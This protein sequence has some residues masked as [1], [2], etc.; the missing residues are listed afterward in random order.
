MYRIRNF[1]LSILTLIALGLLSYSSLYCGKESSYAL[2]S[3]KGSDGA[4]PKGT[5][6]LVDSTLYGYTSA[7]GKYG[8]GVI[9]KLNKSGTDFKAVYDFSDGTDNATGNEPH[10]DAMYFY[11]DHLYGAALYGG[12]KNNGVIFRINPD[13]SGYLPVHVFNG[14]D[15]DGAQ[16]H[17]G[18]IVLNDVLY[19]LTAEGGIEKKG[20]LY[21]MN[22]DGS[23]FSV[24][25]SFSKGTGHNPHGRLTI[26]SDDS[27][28]FGITR[29]GGTD[30]LGAIFSINLRDTSYKVL[31]NFSKGNQNGHTAQHG[32]LVRVDNYLYGMTYSGG[33]KDKGIIF[34]INE[35]GSDF[36]ILHSFD[37]EIGNVN[38]G[39]SPYGSLC[40]S[41]GFLYGTTR[42][43]GAMDEGTVF[44]ITPSGKYYEI[45]FS[46]DKSSSG[47]YPI[48]NVI[49][50]NN[51]K[52]IY[53]FGQVGGEFDHSGKQQFGTINGI[54]ID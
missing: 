4:T 38:D 36:K 34:G 7:G 33:K 52:E 30:K 1:S 3:F 32:Y 16:P 23:D 12:E 45:L 47:A 49:L 17:S 2:F 37:D 9:F 22:P 25:Y 35:D 44:R 39:H 46:F 31:H 15:T 19:G 53:V 29:T 18:I 48:D 20:T 40:Y 42:K 5:M 54:K 41:N 28:L 27:T 13:G 10:H 51:G 14:S 50:N 26:G 21:R 43:G 24:L 6:T 8:K 11:K